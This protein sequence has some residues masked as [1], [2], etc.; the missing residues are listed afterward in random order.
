MKQVQAQKQKER[1]VVDS[2]ES[3]GKHSHPAKREASLLSYSL[4]Y[5]QL[6]TAS[7]AWDGCY[8]LCFVMVIVMMVSLRVKWLWCKLRV[9]L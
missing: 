5:Q 6:V 9:L 2:H 4:P 7:D 8:T 3:V 1:K